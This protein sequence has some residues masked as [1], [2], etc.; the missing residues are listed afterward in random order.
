MPVKVFIT[1]TGQC[2]SRIM[3]LDSVSMSPSEGSLPTCSARSQKPESC[4]GR[5]VE[6]CNIHHAPDHLRPVPADIKHTGSGAGCQAQGTKQAPQ[7]SSSQ[8]IRACTVEHCIMN[9]C[10]AQACL[11]LLQVA[12][13][14][15]ALY[16]LPPLRLNDSC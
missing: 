16:L 11:G 2:L 8:G 14:S 13:S 10:G 3:P 6:D 7:C 12:L 15:S 5:E 9:L 1:K 4:R